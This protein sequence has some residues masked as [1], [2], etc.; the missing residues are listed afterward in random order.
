MTNAVELIANSLRKIGFDPAEQ[1]LAELRMSVF[2]TAQ[3][4]YLEK[5]QAALAMGAPSGIGRMV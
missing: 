5:Q 1:R 4:V 3:D 2:N